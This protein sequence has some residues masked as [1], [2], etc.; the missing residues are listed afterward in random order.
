MAAEPD[1][2]LVVALNYYA[3]YV[4]GVTEAARVIAE[5]LAASGL[6]V[7]VVAGRHESGLPRRE[8]LA[9]VQI[10]RTGV[11]ARFGK[12]IVSPTFVPTVV[13]MAG[14]A[15]MLLLHAPMLEAGLIAVAVRH[16]PIVTLYHC[17]VTLPPGMLNRL[18]ER[19]LDASHRLACRRSAAVVVTTDDYARHSR[20]SAALRDR[21]VV[22]PPP[23]VVRGRGSPSF[24]SSSGTHVGFLGRIVEEKG[25][26][27]LVKGFRGLDDPQA[28][29]L[30][31]GDYTRVAGGSVVDQV[32]AEIGDD[33]RI[34]LLGFLP[35]DSLADF[36][37]S[38][39]IFALP[40]VTA[41]EAFGLVQ[42]EAMM[43][44]V[45]SLTSDLPGVRIPVQRTGFGAIVPPRDAAAITDAIAHLRDG[46]LDREAGSR[47]TRELYEAR[48]VVERFANLLASPLG[49]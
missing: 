27:Y 39:D 38:I 43:A 2:D 23:A 41:L 28:R 46:N 24:R 17:D 29:L 4:S 13:R 42:V 14:R 26:E 35:E 30:I 49:R 9:G 32:R 47:T 15:R 8:R 7:A 25:L 33:T 16:T 5:G 11:V 48:T 44:G 36:Y 12:G 22:I 31:G 20:V 3:P 34:S 18:Q 40:S 19:A 21:E 10:V 1:Y 6:K 45:P 37:A